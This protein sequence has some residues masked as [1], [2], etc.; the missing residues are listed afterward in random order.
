ML[1]PVSLQKPSGLTVRL[2]IYFASQ[3]PLWKYRCSSV[4]IVT[5][6]RAE[7]FLFPQN[8]ESLPGPRSTLSTFYRA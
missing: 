6:Q 3:T 5:T 2:Y 7:D 1:L 4:T 8:R